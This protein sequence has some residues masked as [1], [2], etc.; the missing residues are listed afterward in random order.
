MNDALGWLFCEIAFRGFDA[1]GNAAYHDDDDVTPRWWA[2][3]PDAVLSASYR[4][5]CWFYGRASA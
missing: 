4:A 3:V 2:V 1:L 5:G